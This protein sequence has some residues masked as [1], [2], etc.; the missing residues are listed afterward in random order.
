MKTKLLTSVFFLNSLFFNAQTALNFDGVNDYVVGTNNTTLNLSEGTV[1]AWIKT[2][3]AGSGSRGII[4]KPLQYGMALKDNN[5]IVSEWGQGE[6]NTNVNL[7][8]NTWHHVAFSF[9]NMVPNGSKLYID[10][11]PALAF[12]YQVSSNSSQ[13]IIVG[14]SSKILNYFNGNIDQV[15]VW[16]TQKTDAEILANYKKCIVGN[17]TGLVMYWN[18]DEATGTTATDL[19]SGNNNNGTLTNMD[20]PS[21]WLPGYDCN[22]VAHYPFNGNAKDESGNAN[23]GTVNG[24][25][26]TT[27]RF[28]NANS[29]YEFDGI[30]NYIQVANSTSLNVFNSDLTVSMWIYNDNPLLTDF[31]YKGISKGG[32]NTGAGYELLYSNFWND[33]TLHFTTGSGGNNV[34]A[35]NTYNNQWIMLTGTYENATTTKKIFINGIEQTIIIQQV[36]NLKSSLNDLFIGRRD[37]ANNYS[38]FV[39][40]KMD[41]VRIYNKAL[42]ASEITSL[43]NTNSL[44]VSKNQITKEN[45]F[46]VFNNTLH[47]KNIQKLSDIKTVEVYNLLGQ[48]IFKTTKIT[49][50]IALNNLQKGIYVLKVETKVNR[51]STLKFIIN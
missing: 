35:F 22:L 43:Y 46:Y 20:A 29:A 27:D 5:L 8:D 4:V 12:T 50:Q 49:E 28:G 51:F 17:E 47:F 45:N 21:V 37:P 36:D 26:L 3:N 32:W 34:Y 14:A 31:T 48:N 25:T 6:K 11:L 1:E 18:F 38:G 42:S 19:S 33:G 23:H 2:P 16:N 10:G 40:G 44:A 13:Q 30:N 24:A 15:R 9:S 7:A 41:E 39:K